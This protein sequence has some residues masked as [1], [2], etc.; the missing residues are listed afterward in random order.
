MTVTCSSYETDTWR[1]LG[2]KLSNFQNAQSLKCRRKQEKRKYAKT[3]TNFTGSLW[4]WHYAGRICARKNVHHI[5][6]DVCTTTQDCRILLTLT[7]NK[8]TKLIILR[9]PIALGRNGLGKLNSIS[10]VVALS[11][12]WQLWSAT[13]TRFGASVTSIP[14]PNREFVADQNCHPVQSNAGLYQQVSVLHRQRDIR[15]STTATIQT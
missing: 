3:A 8:V 4:Y 13:N 12:G 7:Q 5:L 15:H 11:I 10:R 9:N 14:A 6:S 2:Q 1:L